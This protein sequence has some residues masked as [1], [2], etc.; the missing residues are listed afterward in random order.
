MDPGYN[1]WADWL[2]KFHTWPEGIQALWVLGLTATALGLIAGITFMFVA[3]TRMFRSAGPERS[4]DGTRIGVQSIH[5]PGGAYLRGP[6]DESRSLRLPH[7]G[8]I[9]GK[10]K[11]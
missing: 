5:R 8:E 7:D 1:A 2:S 4:P 11:K 3:A 10:S 9:L 6:L